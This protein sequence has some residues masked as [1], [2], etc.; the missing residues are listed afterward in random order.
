MYNNRQSVQPSPAYFKLIT[1]IHTA[2]LVG[3]VLF[4]VVSYSITNSKGLNLKPGDDVFFYIALLLVIGGMLA[5][6][7]LFKKQVAKLLDKATLPEK[8]AA[9]Q[10]ALIRRFALSNG[11]SMFGIVV[12]MLT[13]NL[14]YLILTAINVLYFIWIRPTKDKVKEDLN[15]TYEEETAMEGR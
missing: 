14:F 5:G 12:Y 7:F 13:G 3:Q 9:Y 4:G 11:P 8:L 10:A 15:L 1:S 6:T 2:L